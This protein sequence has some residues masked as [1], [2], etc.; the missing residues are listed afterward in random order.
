MLMQLNN[1]S[2]LGNEEQTREQLRQVAE[3][4]NGQAGS[5]MRVVDSFETVIRKETVTV[6][7]SEGD[8]QSFTM[9]QWITIFDGNNGPTIL[10]I[11]GP[12]SRWDDK[13]VE[14]FI[15]SIQ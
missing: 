7:V 5:S 9:R 1:G 6:T 2:S 8:Y 14:D 15:K 3:Q 12:T 13:L 11:Q 10:M 4:Q